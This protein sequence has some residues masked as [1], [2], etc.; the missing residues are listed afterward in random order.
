M[1]T[2]RRVS[3]A[4]VVLLFGGA[5]ILAAVAPAQAADATFKVKCVPPAGGGAPVEGE[6]TAKISA[7]ATA[8]VGDEV[9]VS[10]ETVKPA[11]N[12]TDLM[13]IPKDSVV[14]TGWF[15]VSGGGAELKVVG[16]KKNPEIPKKAPMV[17]STMKGKL[18]LTK[19]GKI[20]LTPG[21]YEVAVS[22][23]F[24]TFVTKCAPV[25]TVTGGTTIDV[26]A[27]S[28]GGTTGG[29]TTGGATTG[30]ATTG[31]ATTGGATTGGAT[32]GGATTGGATTGGATTGSTTGGGGGQT[33]FPG[34][35]VEVAFDCGPVVPGGI[36]TPVTVNAKKNG[37]AYDL[38]VKTAK[39]AMA[40]PMALPAG[41]LKPSMNV[42]LGGADTGTVKVS[43]PANAEPI[44]DKA[45]VS[46]SDMTGTYK[47]G[48][49]G[50]VTLTPDQLTIDVTMAPGSTP[51]NVPCKATSS[52]V[53]LE[54]DTTAQAGG[55]GSP[56]STGSTSAGT[57]SGSGG[58][59]ETG[60]QDDGGI[61]ALA[62][63][64]GTVIL[65]G[66]AV[67]T[68]TPWRRLRGTR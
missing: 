50:K 65:L 45:P 16:E 23:P 46:L 52:A 26:S 68:F 8:K 42:K 15:T 31:G 38:T 47:P 58:L 63:V 14:P 60:A 61:K 11:S 66:G 2:Q 1:K 36:K 32:T 30:G 49:T 22:F 6:T 57:P 41:A 44:P 19:A 35:A 29:A 51:I 10:W 7:P 13:V 33:D 64:A 20:T 5:G 48:K 59:A 18:K 4:A 25:G 34:K 3:A 12:N 27:G 55:S 62:L 37:G 67:F 43:G 24:G 21:R 54:L 17:M 39:G 9:D 53:S 56:S 40:A 28:T